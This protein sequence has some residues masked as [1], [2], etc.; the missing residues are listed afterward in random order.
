MVEVWGSGT[1]LRPTS[2]GVCP[3]GVCKLALLFV[4]L[5]V[6][7]GYGYGTALKSG[8]NEHRILMSMLGPQLKFMFGLVVLLGVQVGSNSRSIQGTN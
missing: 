5:P 2:F 1:H 4:A 8:M 6:A 3:S 7:V